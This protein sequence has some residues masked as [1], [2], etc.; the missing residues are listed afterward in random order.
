MRAAMS[1][2]PTAAFMKDYS[3]V[4]KSAEQIANNS[5]P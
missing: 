5:R 4:L 2:D 3:K 1:N